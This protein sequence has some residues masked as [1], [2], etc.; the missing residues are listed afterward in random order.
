MVNRAATLEPGR[1]DLQ[2]TTA[3][4][5]PN[6]AEAGPMKFAYTTGDRPLEGFTIKRGVGVG[7]F[8][9][10][11]FATSDAGKEVALKRIARNLDV[12]IRGVSQCLNLKHPNLIAVYDIK[13][14]SLGEG[15]VVMEFVSGDSLKD[16]LDRH[17]QG[18]PLN[19][20]KFWFAGIAA[21][22]AYL[23]DHGIV[24]R[25]LK[26]GNIFSD[27]G[28]VKIGDYGLSK[29]ISCSRRSGQ[30]E[31]VGTF[32]YMAPEIGKGVYGKE[33]DIYA[34]GI[35]L[36]ELLTGRVPFE[37]ETSQEIILKHLTA[38]PDLRNIPIRFRRVIERALFKDPAKRFRTVPDMLHAL[39]FD[40]PVSGRARGEATIPSSIPPVVSAVDSARGEESEFVPS[41]E[42]DQDEMVFGPVIEVIPTGIAK[43][44][45]VYPPPP[46]E[47][48]AAAVASGY[49]RLV[50][51]W[52]TANLSTPIK[53][54]LIV[55]ALLLL[56]LNSEW[57]LP[58]AMTLGV[59]YLIYLAA[60]SLLVG[61]KPVGAMAGP[62]PVAV[63]SQATAPVQR[64]GRRE[65]SDRTPWRERARETLARQP[66]GQ[67]VAELV[68]S[69]LMAAIVSAVFCVILLLAGG[70][71][72]D[73]SVD[74]WTL[75]AWLTVTSIL[76]SWAILTA[77]KFWEG[78]AEDDVRRRF[79][80]LMTGLGIGAMAFVLSRALLIRLTTAEMFNVL[81]LP[82]EVI[83]RGM[84]GLDGGP[85]LAAFLAFFATLFALVRWWRQA[86]PLRK[87]RFSIWGATVCVFCAM[88]IPWQIPWGFLLAA[89]M[90]VSVQLSAPWMKPA[91]RS[92][93]RHD[94]GEI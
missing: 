70:R 20:V 26:P 71:E 37:G 11:Y 45:V 74:T 50:L 7:G 12:E 64:R 4:P 6:Y 56:A 69:L 35:I 38:D 30:T 32:H 5:F 47:P 91:E 77:S 28:V 19:E 75:Y 55:A 67:R 51:W 68:G 72:L 79:V 27:E 52:S 2:A 31:S 87:T 44:P 1:H 25:D 24:H 53:V 54:V 88:L 18:I 65:R 78:R 49:R 58:T 41:V 36:C 89:S 13:Y 17:P 14:D 93:I 16:V 21:G 63:A 82:R 61:P 81:D 62:I 60:R 43:P 9:E 80:L 86:D 57:L 83:P 76:G 94:S 84:Y 59:L 22:V 34:L 15:W 29:F 92:R 85:N 46:Q 10:V 33:I 8:G 39:E 23:H 73:A 42:C 3:K 90:T 48:I 66:L 40:T